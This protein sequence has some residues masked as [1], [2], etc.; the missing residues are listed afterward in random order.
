MPSNMNT[1]PM[2]VVMKALMAAL[3]ADSFPYQKPIN[4]YEHRPMI[5]QPTNIV[6]RLSETTSVYM[7]KANR[8]KRE[9]IGSMDGTV[10]VC[11]VISSV[12][13]APCGG[14]PARSWSPAGCPKLW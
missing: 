13:V 9:Y 5:S 8:L 1:S 4:R 7:P 14:R 10:C 2:R 6:S 3:R 11:P 12:T